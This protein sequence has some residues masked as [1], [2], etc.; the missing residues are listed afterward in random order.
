MNRNDLGPMAVDRRDFLRFTGGGIAV[1]VTLKDSSVLSEALEQQRGYP[2][3]FNAYL[4]IGEDGRVTV[5]SGKIEMGQGVQTSLAQMAAEELRVPLDAI[6]MVMGDTDRCVWDA[7]TWGSLTTRVFGPALRAAA[8][9]AHQVLIELAA[10]R[11][12]VPKDKLVAENGVVSVAGG[13]GRVTYGE[14]AK[15]QKIERTLSGEAALRAVKDF[16]VMGTS[17]KR[18]DRI[19][20]VTGAAHYA[21]DVRLPGMLRAR[22]LRP[23]VH[24]ATLKSVD[25]SEAERVPGV[26]VVNQDGLVAVLHEDRDTADR[27]LGLIRA[28]FDAPQAPFDDTSVWDHFLAVAPTGRTTHEEGKLDVGERACAKLFENTYFDGYVAHAPMEPHTSLASVQGDKI[29][30][31]ASTQSPFGDQGR[32]AQA[33]GIEPEN[34]RVLTPYVGGGFG[35]KSAGGQTLEAARLAWI[36]R[37]PVQV[38][39]TREEEFFYDT[40]HSAAVV[41]VRSGIDGAG[42]L[43]LWD[44]HVYMAGT[45]GSEVTY[46]VPNASVVSHSAQNAHLFATGPWRAPGANTNTFARESQID[47][48]AADAGIDPLEFRLR[49]T[50][51]PRLRSVLEAVAK[52]ADWKPAPAPSGRGLGIACGMDAG[53]YVAHVAQVAVDKATGE[54]RVERMLCAQEMGIVVDPD[55]AT[56]QMEGCITQGLGYA[57]MEHIRFRGGDILDRNFNTYRIPRFSDLPEIETVLVGND[58]L[59]PQGG[60]EPAIVCI[61]AVIANAIYDACGSRMFTMP[62]TPEAVRAGMKS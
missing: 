10:D 51:D 45:R 2:A 21:G 33:L 7:G 47:I 40:F 27:A 13:R 38:M 35:G 32:I 29:T 5:L 61:G 52:A 14:L 34:V 62:F 31:W 8:A 41:K 28:D 4:R 20:K 50:T 26:V 3:D 37:K 18:F 46:D 6:D 19:E 53:T 55:G 23:P 25:T 11:L 1:F 24:G 42:R 57:L 16:T 58:D 44:Y 43:Q 56:M 12:G 59:A 39:W 36:T 30:V 60:G 49:N 22:L 9:K 48:M 17:P 15:G 54:V